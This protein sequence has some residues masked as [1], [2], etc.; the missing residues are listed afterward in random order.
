MGQL[1][2]SFLMDLEKRMRII[3]SQEYQRLNQN[4]YWR[5]LAREMPSNGKSERLIWLLD[6]AKIEYVSR[7]GAEVTF[8]DLL[9]NTT[10]FTAKAAT[11]GLELN[12]FQLD[13]HDGGG[14]QLA[15]AWT[16]QIAAYGAYWPQKQVAAAIRA[17]G[18][19]Y[20]NVSFFNTAHPLNPFDTGLGVYANDFTGGASGSY[21]GA[22]P[23]S[24][25]TIDV[26]LENL[27]KAI[28]YVS[29]IKMPNG[30]DPRSL[31]ISGIM[32]PSALVPRMQQLTN[33]KYIAQAAVSGGGSGD[34]ES[35]V[36]NWGLSEPIE[37]PELGANFGGSDSTYYLLA[38]G[39]SSDEM[40][41]LIYV[42]REP[43]SIVYNGEMT[44]AQLARANKLQWLTR[45]R[46]VVAYG[47]PYFLFRCRAT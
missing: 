16:R 20:D 2:P 46:N 30:E 10:E 19:S 4:I 17:N 28:A 34:I 27:G 32:G 25:V 3:G 13:D 31:R 42:N 8:D 38:E 9:T 18:N 1:T 5:K 47:H 15:A 23:I 44:D 14:V 24:G 43:F 35:I 41:S 36:R 7:L 6:T 37:A 11:A 26:A 33:A 40:G 12:R 29:S 22:V 45:G 39:L 21:P